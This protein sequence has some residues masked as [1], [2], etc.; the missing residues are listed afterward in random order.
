MDILRAG[1]KGT[2]GTDSIGRKG[3][4]PEPADGFKDILSETQ[5]AVPADAVKG[6]VPAQEDRIV[7]KSTLYFGG[8]VVFPPANASQE[9]LKEWNDALDAMPQDERGFFTSRVMLSLIYGDY[10]GEDIMD[11]GERQ[12]MIQNR[13]DTLGC[14]SVM[15]LSLASIKHM[16]NDNI[17]GG[18]DLIYVNMMRRS[19]ADNEALLLRLLEKKIHN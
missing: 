4:I 9:F 11:D 19:V 2:A 15:K 6:D 14:S 5:R 12:R 7:S 1:I 8:G 10:Y 18:N 3:P 13:I 17:A 16:L